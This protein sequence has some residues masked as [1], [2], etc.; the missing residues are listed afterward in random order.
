MTT[1]VYPTALTAPSQQDPQA[2]RLGIGWVEQQLQPGQH[3]LVWTPTRPALMEHPPLMVF[4]RANTS[5]TV[6]TPAAGWL[7]GNT[8]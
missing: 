2:I 5:A 4:A 8:E 7:G 1:R 3:A 6:R